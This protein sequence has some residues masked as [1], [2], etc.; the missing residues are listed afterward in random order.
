MDKLAQSLLPPTPSDRD[1]AN[2]LVHF[3]RAT[4]FLS[5]VKTLCRWEVQAPGILCG[6]NNFHWWRVRVAGVGGFC[7]QGSPA[8]V[9]PPDASQESTNTG[10]D[11]AGHTNYDDGRLN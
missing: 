7:A 1:K 3:F 4:D 10:N 11:Q 2:A 8:L 5:G 9:L 6:V